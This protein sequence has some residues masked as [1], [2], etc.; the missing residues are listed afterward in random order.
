MQLEQQQV[1]AAKAEASAQFAP[2]IEAMK[3]AFRDSDPNESARFFSE[4]KRALDTDLVSGIGHIAQLYG[5]HPLQLAAAIQQRYGQQPMQPSQQQYFDA[6]QFAHVESEVRAFEAANPDLERHEGAVM[7]ILY[8]PQFQQSNQPPRVKLRTAL[9]LAI[10]REGQ[11]STDDKI[12]R[13]VRRAYDKAQKR[14]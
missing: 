11:L 8:T 4:T 5:A 2:G 9:D 13:S 12:E 6:Q 3:S 14:G 1:A 10:K 7:E